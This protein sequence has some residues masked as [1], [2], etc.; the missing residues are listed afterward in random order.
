[1]DHAH[2]VD[3]S[4][5]GRCRPARACDSRDNPI[6]GAT[7]HLVAKLDGFADTLLRRRRGLEIAI[8]TAAEAPDCL[9]AQCQAAIYHLLSD[10]RSGMQGARAH[11]ERASAQLPTATRREATLVA[12][13]TAIAAQQP[14]LASQHFLALARIAPT[15]R[16]SAYVGH[17]HF[18]NHG[19]FGAMM[20]HA[21]LF[22]AADRS[23]PFGL[24][25]LSFALGQQGRFEPA[26]ETGLDACARDPRIPWAHHALAH[27]YGSMDRT[28]DGIGVLG[29]YA[30]TWDVCGSSMYTHNWWHLM[31]LLLAHGERT[32]L[33][34][35]YDR[36]LAG[37]AARSLSSFV[38]ATSMLIR[39][40]LHGID[41]E[42]RWRTV[43]D[44]AERRVGDH[45]LPFLDVHYAFALAFDGR[46][47]ALA[48]LRAGAKR[49]AAADSETAPAWRLAAVPL[50]DAIVLYARGRCLGAVRRRLEASRAHW[51]LLG[52]SSAQR[53]VFDQVAAALATGRITIAGAEAG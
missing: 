21:R 46:R 45:V 49:A 19:H 12:A 40:V 31:V 9:V 18:L 13:L 51:P 29:R 10:S 3:G 34:A 37:E 27:A 7:S 26:E 4:V 36:H 35:L 5:H 22:H 17:L 23:D 14:A 52:G 8:D 16:L 25:M 32:G 38:N 6:T 11:L 41:V 47:C 2:P 48:S 30:P 53:A 24:G 43:A 28:E 1:M 39:L 33:L 15:D 20:E 44:E 42:D 50:I